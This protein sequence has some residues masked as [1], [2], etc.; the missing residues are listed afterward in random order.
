M[1]NKLIQI[2]PSENGLPLVDVLATHLKTSKRKAKAL[3]DS[4][5]VF[6][7]KERT[8]IAQHPVRNKDIIEITFPLAAPQDRRAK[9]EIIY[10]DEYMLIVNKPPGIVVNQ[11][12]RSLEE[13]L[14][15]ALHDRDICAIHR[16]DRD[17]SGCVM[18]ARNN[19]VKAKMIEVFKDQTVI[20]IYR[21]IARG[22]MPGNITTIHNDIDGESASTDVKILDSKSIAS[23]L[24]LRIRTGRTHQIRKH[25]QFVRCP[26]AGDKNYRNEKKLDDRLRTLPR[27]M[28]HAY[29]LVFPHPY[30]EGEVVRAIAPVPSDFKDALKIMRLK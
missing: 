1:Q 22:R 18:F 12:D 8:W 5:N 28:L 14:R 9:P 15:E 26:V 13:W 7:N 19:K 11:S 16:L 29:K 6:I 2:K 24:E 3:L 23:Y 30:K 27:Q 4:R 10:K 21:A 20:K 25:L 17:T